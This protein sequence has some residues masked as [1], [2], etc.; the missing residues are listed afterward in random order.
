MVVMRM[1]GSGM[2]STNLIAGNMEFAVATNAV[3]VGGGTLNL[4]AGLTYPYNMLPIWRYW[5]IYLPGYPGI[6]SF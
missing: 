5:S 2:I 6:N 3:P 4:A 1:V